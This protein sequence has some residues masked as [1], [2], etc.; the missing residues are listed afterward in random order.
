METTHKWVFKKIKLAF[1]VQQNDKESTQKAWIYQIKTAYGFIKTTHGW[2]KLSF[3]LK[4]DTIKIFNS[5]SYVLYTTR[6][7]LHV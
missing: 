2:N 1:L 7:T 5:H 3:Q 6:H 4:L